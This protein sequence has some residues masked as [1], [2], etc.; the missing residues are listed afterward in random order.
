MHAYV[1]EVCF[2]NVLNSYV[3]H[4]EHGELE[5]VRCVTNPTVIEVVVDLS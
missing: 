3:Q 2:M 5:N 4:Y 1:S